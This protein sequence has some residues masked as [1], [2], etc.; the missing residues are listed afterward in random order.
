MRISKPSGPS[1][2][3]AAA[4]SLCRRAL[5]GVALFSG[6]SNLLML[7]GS[8]YMLELYDRVLPSRSI[9]T[10]LGLYVLAFIV[11]AFQAGLDMVRA[12]I[13]S[14][15]GIALDESL[16]G[17]VYD[18]IVR[19]PLRA[20]SS[21]GIQPL[22]DLDQLRAFLGGSGPIALFDLPWIPLYLGLCFAFHFWLGVTTLIGTIGL[23]V[24]TLLTE[25]NTRTPMR[26]AGEF[27][28]SRNALMEAGRR[29]AE[30]LRAMG[31]SGRLNRAWAISNREYLVRTARA[32]DVAGDLGAIS[33]V[34]RMALQSAVLGV[35]A[36][37]VI[38]QEATAGV[39]IAASILAGRGLAPVDLAIANWRGFIGARQSR[40][41]LEKLLAI[42][43]EEQEPME[44]PTPT[45]ILSVEGVTV[46]PPGASMP[47]ISDVTLT[48]RSGQA[49]GIIGPSA[50]GKSTLARALVGVWQ[51]LRGK[52]RLDNASLEQ[53]SLEARGKYIG[54]LPQ[55]VE[56]IEGTVAL[57]ISRFEE[58]ADPQSI[59]A[60]A[61]AAGVHEMILRLPDGY[62]TRVG[63]SGAA[64]SAGQRQRIG[65][66]RALYGAPF[67]VVLD[68]PNSNLDSD[69]EEAL[70]QAILG[71]RARGGILLVIAHRPSALAGV[72]QV[73]VM[74]SGRVQLL[75]PKDEILNKL[76]RP[77][78]AP[79]QPLR[80]IAERQGGLS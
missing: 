17:R 73:L 37:L 24:I 58:N 35:G 47:V 80:A 38:M 15:V 50:S 6:M 26:E 46:V 71:V 34:A 48:L 52:V 65:L 7:T 59:L 72:D 41:R 12:R 55:D 23:V 39:M 3:I 57:N 4:L 31:M 77:M 20:N 62:A 22:R 21:G 66:A 70:S 63:E 69:G 11:F 64:L 42:L 56:L 2:E 51:P 33:K 1:S 74:N 44:L 78:T 32:N 67:L 25:F 14:R 27:A 9:P 53:L 19:L 10:L 29:N 60:A 49:L 75:G 16:S 8:M 13:M 79:A 40:E 36:Y 18:A 76:R 61:K 45:A 28:Q 54:Y 5:L 30:V 43:P 68:E